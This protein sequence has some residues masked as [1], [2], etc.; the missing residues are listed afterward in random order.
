M[1]TQAYVEGVSTRRVDDLVRSLGCDGISKSQVSRIGS[2]LDEV[3]SSFL[4]QPLD[5]GPYRYLWLDA[6]TQLVRKEGRAVQ[7]SVVVATA[8]NALGQARAAGPRRRHL[9]GRSVLAELPARARGARPV[10]RRA[11]HLGRAP[12]PQ[13]GDRDGLRGASWQ[14]AAAAGGRGRGRL[15]RGGATADRQLANA[16]DG[17]LL[18][19]LQGRDRGERPGVAAYTAAAHRLQAAT[20]RPVDARVATRRDTGAMVR[21]GCWPCFPAL[22]SGR[23]ELDARSEGS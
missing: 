22:R 15:R 7:V 10:R 18:H 13:G 11:R 8:V 17:A 5:S 3:V 12:G 6:L 1:D 4:E 20:L 23:W 9:R 2:A 19:H 16:Q 21:K 14:A